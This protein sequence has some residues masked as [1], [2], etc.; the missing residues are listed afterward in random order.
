MGSAGN[1]YQNTADYQRF[2]IESLKEFERYK[3]YETIQKC[4]G[5][6]IVGFLPKL[7]SRPK[8][9]GQLN[10]AIYD[11]LSTVKAW[12][13]DNIGVIDCNLSYYFYDLEIQGYYTA[14]AEH[15]SEWDTMLLK[16][17]Q[18]KNIRELFKVI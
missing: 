6:L 15:P 16:R 2:K 17:E 14:L 8:D 10:G 18:A 12:R 1:I 4:H 7:R 3:P 9:L 5:I 11:I 13:D